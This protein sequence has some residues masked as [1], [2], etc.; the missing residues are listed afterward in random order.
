MWFLKWVKSDCI[1]QMLENEL[2]G[3]TRVALEDARGSPGGEGVL[4]RR[5]C[6]AVACG[7]RWPWR[8]E[9]EQTLPAK[10]A[11]KIIKEKVF[12]VSVPSGKVLL[13]PPAGLYCGPRSDGPY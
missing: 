10:T 5:R 3:Q 2:V 13:R 4:S 8:G 12:P 6:G 9:A 1:L 7:R 11:G